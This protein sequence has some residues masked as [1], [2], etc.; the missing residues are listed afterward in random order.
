M[1]ATPYANDP[2]WVALARM[3]Y[4]FTPEDLA[5]IKSVGNVSWVASQLD[6]KLNEGMEAVSKLNGFVSLGMTIDQVSTYQPFMKNNDLAGQELGAT[7]LI[8]RLYSK[9]QLFEMLVEHFN[10]YIHI[11]LH[12]AWQSR[13]S[14]DRDVIRANILGNFPDLLVASSLHPS[15]LE[16]LNGNDNT[17]DAPN[18][19]YGR[20]LQELHTISSKAG[21][22]Q[23]DVVNASRVFSGI[24][25]NYDTNQLVIDPDQHWMGTVSVF[26]WTHPNSSSDP[27]DIQAV[28]E[29]LV[30]FLCMR[31]E[32]ARAFSIRMARRFVTDD[33]PSSL[34]DH[35]STKYLES[36]GSIPT[37]FKAMIL[38][39]EL[40]NL[41]GQKVKRPMEHFSSIVRN[42]NLQLATPIQPGDSKQPDDY[43]H[44]SVM[45]N[46]NYYL[47][48][49]GH[50][51]MAWPFPNGF[52]DKS[53]P[54]T[55]LNGQMRRWNYGVAL[56]HGSNDQD[57]MPPNY[58][59]MLQGIASDPE[60]IV[61]ALSMRLLGVTLASSDRSDILAIVKLAYDS[62]SSKTKLAQYAQTATS[63]ILSMPTWNFR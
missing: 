32:T 42:L 21:Y 24:S 61:D 6:Q 13:M 31:P 9:R 4:G 43:F 34:I 38:S 22:S 44:D 51:P 47:V 8:R 25:W 23:D 35:M 26:G 46:I 29:S 53:N 36:R 57:F 30:R 10:D 39:P 55:T 28:T 18:E 19:N 49:Q 3:T 41:V 11:A 33:P 63:L 7:S 2:E 20:E 60:K 48:A 1:S 37:T 5:L 52:P 54:W 40:N 62:S 14:F 16:Y 59:Q 56:S 27:K 50:E 58:D 45:G 12:S 15:M 17:K